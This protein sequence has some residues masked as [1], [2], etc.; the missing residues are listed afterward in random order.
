MMTAVYIRH[1]LLGHDGGSSTS[2]YL[3]MT[4]SSNTAVIVDGD[5][6]IRGALYE[7]TKK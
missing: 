2:T 1:L 3:F 4:T 5:S 6:T 7:R